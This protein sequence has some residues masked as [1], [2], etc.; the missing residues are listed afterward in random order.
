MF[1]SLESPYV[2][3]DGSSRNKRSIMMM[4]NSHLSE[5][6]K[7]EKKESS[8]LPVEEAWAVYHGRKQ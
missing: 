4:Y 6:D 2:F 3:T 5:R 7:Q 8:C 1:C